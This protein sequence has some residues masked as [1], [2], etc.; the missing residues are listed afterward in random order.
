LPGR[1]A[2]CG[3]RIALS[4]LLESQA[5]RVLQAYSRHFDALEVSTEGQWALVTGVRNATAAA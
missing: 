4:G 2:R 3:G 1:Y 5:P